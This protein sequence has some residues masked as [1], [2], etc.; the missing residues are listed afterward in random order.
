[1]R[2]D[3]AVDCARRRSRRGERDVSLT[4]LRLPPFE[5]RFRVSAVT[6]QLHIES[7]FSFLLLLCFFFPPFP[8]EGLSPFKYVDGN[9]DHRPPVV[10]RKLKLF[11]S[12]HRRRRSSL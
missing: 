2:A 9:G 12:R 11:E 4:E 7:N 6:V 3:S 5:I 10:S 1:M 8:E